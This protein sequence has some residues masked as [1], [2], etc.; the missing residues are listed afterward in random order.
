[1]K[2]RVRV[3]PGAGRDRIE[4]WLGETLKLSVSAPPEKGK[5]NRAVVDLLSKGLRVARS[6]VRVV[7]GETS[8]EKWVEIDGLSEA[9]FRA[10]LK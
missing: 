5:A 6:S 2:L 7:S 10:R 8:R 4:G 3:H 1:V 9:E